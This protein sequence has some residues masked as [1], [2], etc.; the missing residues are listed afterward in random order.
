MDKWITK[1][2]RTNVR[3]DLPT[4]LGTF[5]KA[6]RRICSSRSWQHWSHSSVPKPWNHV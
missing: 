4:E 1:T 2:K 5:G 3:T 6:A